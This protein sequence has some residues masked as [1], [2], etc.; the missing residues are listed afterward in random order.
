MLKFKSV[1]YNCNIFIMYFLF[2]F[3]QIDNSLWSLPVVLN[4]NKLTMYQSGRSVVIRTDF[5]LTVRYDWEHHLVVTLS[6]SYSCKTRGLCGNFNGNPNDDFT[7]PS[8]TQAGGEVAFGSSWKVPGLVKDAL[9]RD[10]CV[11]G[12]ERCEHNQMKMWEGDRF[13]GLITLTVNGPFNK[14]HAV[15][16]P[17]AYLE[18]CKYDVC[19]GGGLRHFLCRALEAYTEACQI[20]GV[21]VQDWRKMA[22]CRK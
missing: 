10:D 8:G 16:D 3:V 15:I 2:S 4:N 17:Q 19:M 6:G 12:C 11:G 22:R 9:C 18:N 20:A 1:N 13:C 5:G 14:C 21:Q 7:T